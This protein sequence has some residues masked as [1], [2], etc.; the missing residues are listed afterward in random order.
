MNEAQQ[1]HAEDDARDAQIALEQQSHCAI[2]NSE[3]FGIRGSKTCSCDQNVC[4]RCWS[5]T[6]EC[7]NECAQAQWGDL[8]NYLI[9]TLTES[10]FNHSFIDEQIG[11]DGG[12]VL[13]F[14]AN[15]GPHIKVT[16]SEKWEI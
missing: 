14:E 11:E 5:V 15:R 6:Y 9:K 13:K 3:V 7:C 12:Y 2:C 16:V 1:E 10:E 4:F 8:R